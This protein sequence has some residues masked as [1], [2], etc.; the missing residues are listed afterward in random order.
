MHDIICP[1][2]GERTL[3]RDVGFDLSDCI[4]S[5]LPTDAIASVG[6]QFHFIVKEEQLFPNGTPSHGAFVPFT[7][8]F[9]TLRLY[10]CRHTG[11]QSDLLFGELYTLCKQKKEE[12]VYP[13]LLYS[14]LETVCITCFSR[15]R[16]PIYPGRLYKREMDAVADFLCRLYEEDDQEKE[17]TLPLRSILAKTNTTDAE[18]IPDGLRLSEQEKTKIIPKCCPRCGFS[19]P[20]A[21]GH[22]RQRTLLAAAEQEADAKDAVALFA[23]YADPSVTRLFQS[24]TCCAFLIDG[25]IYQITAPQSNATDATEYLMDNSRLLRQTDHLLYQFGKQDTGEDALPERFAAIL[26]ATAD[27]RRGKDGP[28]SLTFF[29]SDIV[30]QNTNANEFRNCAGEWNQ[31]A[32]RAATCAARD[33]IYKTLPYLCARLEHACAG[34]D[35][36]F[37]PPPPKAPTTED[38]KKLLLRFLYAEKERASHVCSRK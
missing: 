34:K 11:T 19:F 33:A 15:N 37:L 29:C 28:D 4:S 2:C 32:I 18:E 35:R 30:L 20:T 5:L 26:G 12:A 17:L 27:P 31:E 38:G 13:P 23:A 36:A 3:A 21:F 14:W 10:I 22:Y 1:L 6:M 24:D 9:E 7:I 16:Q 8:T 25:L